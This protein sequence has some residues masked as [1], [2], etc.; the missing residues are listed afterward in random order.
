MKF[1]MCHKYN[2]GLLLLAIY[3]QLNLKKRVKQTIFYLDFVVH[4]I[5]YSHN[6]GKSK[7]KYDALKAYEI[8]V[9]NKF[10]LN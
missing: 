9:S 4:R 1:L 10:K 8:Q 3:F 7:Y 2:Y 5:D 6:F